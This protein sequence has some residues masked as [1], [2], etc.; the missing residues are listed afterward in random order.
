MFE[1]LMGMGV[2][3]IVGWNVLPQPQ[4]VKNLYSRW[5][6]GGGDL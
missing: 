6:S 3:L 4:W 2:G 5:F 1:F